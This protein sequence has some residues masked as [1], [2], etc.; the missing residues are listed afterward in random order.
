[1]RNAIR[2]QWTSSS[3]QV[4]KRKTKPRTLANN[5]SPCS[6]SGTPHEAAEPSRI[7]TPLVVELSDP[8]SFHLGMFEIGRPLGKG[9]LGR[10]YLARER[11]NGFLCAL[12][13]LYK[14]ELQESRIEE[15]VHREIEIQSNVRHPNILRLYGHFQDSQ[16]VCLILEFAA[17]G[18][19]YRQLVK[20]GRFSE[21][22]SARYI[23]QMA[24]AL[25]Y[26]HRKH[27]MHRDI[28]PEN[29][30]IGIHGEIKLSDFGW[31][32]YSPNR[33]R[34]TVCGTLQYLSPELIQLLEQPTSVR[35]DETID[36]WSLGVLTYEL[37]VGQ[38]PFFDTQDC[39][40][41]KRITQADMTVPSFV[42]PEAKDL[43]QKLLVLEPK[44]RASLKEVQ[45]HSWIIKHCVENHNT[46][47]EILSNATS[48][49]SLN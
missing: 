38:P 16:R 31:S 45:T 20:E 17:K 37:V 15:Q 7:S 24:F 5:P 14:K 9:M 43:I 8:K 6:F 36:L 33:R 26:L 35:Y 29:I 40:T 44:R 49:K 30:L 1:M 10:V 48:N 41:Q 11:T 18:E 25:D 34:N 19:L 47:R 13:V 42:S 27:I 4:A 32:V 28:K 21:R 3:S 23:A 39:M 12:K 46:A 2:R 22:K